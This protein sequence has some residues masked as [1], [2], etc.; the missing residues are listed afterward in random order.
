MS[1]KKKSNGG[2][3]LRHRIPNDVFVKAWAKA[4]TAQDVMDAVGISPSGLFQ[5]AKRL[6]EAGV[7]LP[8]LERSTSASR[9]IDVAGLNAML[10]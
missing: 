1:A 8:P 4:T 3:T 5:K 6:R 2:P 10:K 7:K 9:V